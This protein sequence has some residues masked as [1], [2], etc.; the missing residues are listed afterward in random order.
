MNTSWD[1]SK[2][3]YWIKRGPTWKIV[4][5][6]TNISICECPYGLYD[7][8]LVRRICFAVN[9]EEVKSI[10]EEILYQKE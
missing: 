1:R 3:T 8:D 4:S 9:D 5:C 2:Q 10:V 7:D 6:K